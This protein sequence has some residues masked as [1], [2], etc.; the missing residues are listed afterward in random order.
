M[1][2]LNIKEAMNINGGKT[3]KC[4]FGC[5]KKGGYWTVYAHCLS[6]GCF[7]RN[8]YLKAVWSGAKWCFSSALG[9]MIN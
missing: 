4:P 1:K 6:S 9:N 2:R 8:A 3:Y 7:K 5:N